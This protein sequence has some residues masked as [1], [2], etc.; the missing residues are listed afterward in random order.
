MVAFAASGMMPNLSPM[1]N[2]IPNPPIRASM[3]A[4]GRGMP[5]VSTNAR[6][7]GRVSPISASRGAIAS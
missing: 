1:S 6:S 2:G 7:V 3:T 5:K 4:E